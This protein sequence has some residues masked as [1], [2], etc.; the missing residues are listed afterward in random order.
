M[1]A[2]DP[3]TEGRIFEYGMEN[4]NKVDTERQAY[5]SFSAAT[6]GQKL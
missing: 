2:I 3:T 6:T 5:Y 4:Q 1:H